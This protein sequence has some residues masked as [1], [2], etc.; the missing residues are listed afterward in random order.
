MGFKETTFVTIGATLKFDI[1]DLSFTLEISVLTFQ[2][3][4]S[5]YSFPQGLQVLFSSI[6]LNHDYI[7]SY[8]EKKKK[9][10]LNCNHIV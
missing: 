4:Q 3:D 8:M 5:E 2:K 9:N 6:P 1:S 7:Y 10:M